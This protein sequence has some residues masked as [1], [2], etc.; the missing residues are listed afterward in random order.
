MPAPE[1][2]RLVVVAA[3]AGGVQ[4]LRRLLGG[5]SVR[6]PWPLAIVQHLSEDSSGL[7]RLLA[8]ESPLPVRE[9]SHGIAIEPGVAYLAPAG[10]HLMIEQDG[11]FALSVDEK[12][13]YVR[14]SAD[15][16]FETAAEAYGLGVVGVVLTGSNEDGAQ[17]LQRVR[18]LGGLALVQD[19]VEAEERA[20]PEAALAL[21]GADAVLPLAGLARRLNEEAGCSS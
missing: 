16:L 20:M 15:V 10:Y 19:P 11:H 18:E 3:S 4:A 7:A 5:L 12:V 8:S 9:A 13:C 14:P 17:G 21:A 1:H 6:F 2:A